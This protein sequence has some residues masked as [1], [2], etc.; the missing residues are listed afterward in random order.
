MGNILCDVSGSAPTYDSFIKWYCYPSQSITMTTLAGNLEL[1]RQL[2]PLQNHVDRQLFNARVQCVLEGVF[3]PRSDLESLK[4][5][6]CVARQAV[7][8]LVSL[9]FN[10]DNLKNSFRANPNYEI[11]ANVFLQDMTQVQRLRVHAQTDYVRKFIKEYFSPCYYHRHRITTRCRKK[12]VK[13]GFG[14][15]M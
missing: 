6:S 4:P 15:F 7:R 12:K 9:G 2:L 10:L 13:C 3:A 5:C 8:R 1:Q 14:C 11:P